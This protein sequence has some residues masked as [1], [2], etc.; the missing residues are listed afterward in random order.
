[1]LWY[2]NAM[3]VYPAIDLR[4]GKCV[5]LLQGKAEKETVYG[6]APVEQ[7]LAWQNGGGPFLHIV[8]LDGAFEGHPVHL[9]LF[10]ELAAALTIP[11][12]VGGGLRT[13]EDVAA[14]LDAGAARVI[15]GS[16][17]VSNPE[18]V[19]RLVERHGAERIV[20]GIDARNG[21]VQVAGWTETTAICAEDLA[22]RL[23]ALGARIFIYT[24]TATDGMLKGPN[25]EAV[26]AFARAVPDCAVVSSG[27]IHAPSDLA[28]LAALH[29]PNLDGVIIGKAL[30]ENPESLRDY[31]AAA[32]GASCP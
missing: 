3:K 17:A 11:F 32:S 13:D 19:H 26:S 1:M 29:L 5:R 8:D 27:G 31:L 28:A 12:E 14:V 2:A 4:N 15:L 30:Y 16:R 22:Q 7:A 23:A 25:L 9:P 21:F 20:V 10:R 18:A 24:D 6:S